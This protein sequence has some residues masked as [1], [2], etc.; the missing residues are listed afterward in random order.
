M[1]LLGLEEW[2]GSDFMDVVFSTQL[3]LQHFGVPW[4]VFSSME[5]AVQ[6]V[7]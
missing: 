7:K 6:V 4:D 2:V 5:A 3:V 1:R